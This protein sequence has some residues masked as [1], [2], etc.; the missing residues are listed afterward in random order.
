M[1]IFLII[2]YFIWIPTCFITGWVTACAYSHEIYWKNI[3]IGEFFTVLCVSIVPI[4]NF[5][6]TLIFCNELYRRG[7]C[8][9]FLDKPLFHE[10]D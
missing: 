6:G 5:V 2:I 1:W 8:F 9:T 3:T 7:I 4:A 10:R